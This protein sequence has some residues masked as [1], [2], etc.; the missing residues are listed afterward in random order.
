MASV[1]QGASQR[2]GA[3]TSGTSP[4]G[5]ASALSP[6]SSTGQSYFSNFAGPITNH[7]TLSGSGH[8]KDS[9]L[10]LVGTVGGSEVVSSQGNSYRQLGLPLVGNDTGSITVR[11]KEPLVSPMFQTTTTTDVA[12]TPGTYS[13]SASSAFGMTTAIGGGSAAPT[14]FYK[15]IGMDHNVNGLYDTWVV[16]GSP[17]FTG[18]QYGGLLATPLRKIAIDVSWTV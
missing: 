13:P 6:V 12:N 8:F 18:A 3:S 1:D 4:V 14:P 10:S 17:D 2:R 5:Q 7:D 15:M 11:A 9:R 16:K